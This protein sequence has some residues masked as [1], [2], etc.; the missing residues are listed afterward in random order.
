[1][2]CPCIKG[3]V[4]QYLTK[5]EILKEIKNYFPDGIADV[6]IDSLGRFYLVSQTKGPDAFIT[7]SGDA[8]DPI[9]W[10]GSPP[11]TAVGEDAKKGEINYG[12]IIEEI[13][14]RL[15]DPLAPFEL[16]EDQVK[17]GLR[18]TLN[19]YYKWRNFKTKS[20][21]LQLSGNP[22][23]GYE[24]PPIIPSQKSIK[25]I[26]FKPRM[27]FSI[28]A[29]SGFESTIWSQQL[30][31]QYNTSKFLTGGFPADFYI[32]NMAAGD[33]DLILGT[34][35]RWE[36]INDRIHVYPKLPAYTK[37]SILYDGY[38]T[39]EEVMLD[40]FVVSYLTG[41]CRKLI[42]TIRDS[43]GGV[44]QV[45]EQSLQMQGKDMIQ[46]GTDEMKNALDEIKKE[47][48][49]PLLLIG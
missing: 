40:S 3:A 32:L 34:K 42:G 44:L 10:G 47:S 26:L 46:M 22:T 24:I 12:P 7:V 6:G 14:D 11:K 29:N 8:A 33:W 20:I 16:T 30:L 19:L 9:F 15:G 37:V 27:P 31:T 41:W 2:P 48:E 18:E 23:D 17:A 21:T 4:H 49:P 43:F 36:I 45:G 13:K 1:M 39:I 25:E 28:Y 35:P 5:E 38:M